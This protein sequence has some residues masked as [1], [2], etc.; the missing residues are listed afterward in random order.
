MTVESVPVSSP[1]L[2][3][4]STRVAASRIAEATGA[5]VPVHTPTS[6]PLRRK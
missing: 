6:C 3:M 1:K 5:I 4:M 2:S